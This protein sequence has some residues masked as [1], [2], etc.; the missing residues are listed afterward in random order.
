MTSPTEGAQ[1]V[2]DEKD[3]YTCG[4]CALQ[5]LD[6]DGY[7]KKQKGSQLEAPFHVTS[8]EGGMVTLEAQFSLNPLFFLQLLNEEG[9]FLFGRWWLGDAKWTRTNQIC[10]LIPKDVQLLHQGE[11]AQFT[12][13]AEIPFLQNAPSNLAKVSFETKEQRF[14]TKVTKAS[15]QI[16]QEKWMEWKQYRLKLWRSSKSWSGEDKADDDKDKDKEEKAE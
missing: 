7:V 1:K 15:V 2:L 3:E 10:N 16:P 13:D 8:T 6:Q 9:N 14:V 11:V 12:V 4:F 5:I